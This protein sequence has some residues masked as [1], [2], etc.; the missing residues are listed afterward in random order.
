MATD[1]PQLRRGARLGAL[2]GALAGAVALFVLLAGRIVSGS[3]GILETIQDGVTRYVPLPVFDAGIDA[4]GPYAKGLLFAGIA[5]AVPLAGALLGVLVGRT[6]TARGGG[7]MAE[8]ALA[9]GLAW[10]VAEAVVLPLFGAGLFGLQLETDALAVQVPLG[11]ASIA[12]GLVFAG[13]VRGVEAIP[14]PG[15]DRPAAAEHLAETEPA[16][17]S[18]MTR[19]TL[20]GR[21]LVLIGLGSIA[22]SS[23]IVLSR[24]L[25]VTSP[26]LPGR[27]AEVPPGGFG[28]T[29]AATPVE[30]FYVVGKDVLPKAVDA[31]TW[32]LSITG[33]VDRPA[34]YSLDE[35]RALPAVEGYRTLQC[36]S[37]QVVT[38]GRYIGNQRWKGIRARDVLDQAGV[39]PA[40]RFVL[41]RS[42]DGYTESIP[43]DVA[44]DVRTWL[45]Y[46]MGPP[47]SGLTAEHGF[48]L[49]VLIAGR[50]GMKQP[51]YLT[52]I[53]LSE[54]DEPGYWEQRGWDRTAAVRTYSRI[55][56][57]QDG[58][59]VPV[60]RPF[61]V[62]GVASSGDRGISRVE[63]S[64]DGGT[65]WRDAELEPE[66]GPISDLSWVRWRSEV[67]APEQGRLI[68]LARATDARG[69][70]QDA[71]PRAP[72]P[73]GATG[74]HRVTIVAAE[75]L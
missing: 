29:Q 63:L 66:G 10:L 64:A 42:A 44:R 33:L 41:W 22:A 18:G 5:V 4:F 16:A 73:S 30:E 9:T 20:L 15:T 23:A 7:A 69:N 1:R 48:P 32:R 49:R 6:W 38:Y 51:K 25:A 26:A 74:L 62:Y 43:L 8:V 53:V 45:V 40:A 60:D 31:A 65:T 75:G 54:T 61:G 39:Q 50:Y 36:I 24:V 27:T 68:L 21:T 34:E 13:I 71:T 56:L 17:Q 3:N 12:F 47:G 11:V 28:P 72:A 58:D 35:I 67:R 55:D 46:E 19:R 57:P 37:N 2:A 59:Q 70:A 14:M 52:E